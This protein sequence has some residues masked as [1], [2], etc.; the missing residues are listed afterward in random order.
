MDQLRLLTCQSNKHINIEMLFFKEE[1]CLV[2]KTTTKEKRDSVSSLQMV[3]IEVL[4]FLLAKGWNVIAM[5]LITHQKFTAVV[6]NGGTCRDIFYS[7]GYVIFCLFT[8]ANL[9]FYSIFQLKQ[10][11]SISK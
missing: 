5:R 6:L 9:L 10:Y 1:N 11:I 4:T 7:L 2:L 8:Y 3:T